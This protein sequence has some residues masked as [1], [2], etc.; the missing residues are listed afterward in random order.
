VFVKLRQ[1]H[2]KSG[3]LGLL[4]QEGKCLCMLTREKAK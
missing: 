1:A 2:L 4:F 3:R